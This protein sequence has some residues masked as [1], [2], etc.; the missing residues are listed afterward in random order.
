MSRGVWRERSNRGIT[1][2]L[3]KNW[4]EGCRIR[5]ARRR[6]RKATLKHVRKYRHSAGMYRR[7]RW[8]KLEKIVLFI[9]GH[10]ER[11][12]AFALSRSVI[13]VQ[14]QRHFLRKTGRVPSNAEITEVAK[15]LW[16]D[17]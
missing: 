12:I 16:K 7:R 1:D 4:R 9:P 3:A 17:S 8:D 2:G 14:K 10:T 5:D 13:S 15:R 11:Q 6:A